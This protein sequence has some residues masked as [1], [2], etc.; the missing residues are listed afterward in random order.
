MTTVELSDELFTVTTGAI[1]TAERSAAR[2]RRW[3]L[4]A[5]SALAALLVVEIVLVLPYLGRAMTS[6]EQPDLRWVG[7]AVLT[8]L[9]SMGAFAHVQR[10][11]LSVGGA[12]V[13][14]CR[15]A[16]LTYA[17]NA[18]SVTFPGGTALSSGYVYKRLRSWGATVPA[19]GFTI[20]ASGVLSTLSFALL[21]V[22]CAVLAGNGG[23]GSLLVVAGVVVAAVAAWLVQRHHK[24]DLLVRVADR[25]LIRA[26]RVFHRAPEAGIA[27]LHRVVRDL[28]AIKPRNRDWLAGLGFAGLNWV[29]DLAC[30]IACCQAVGATGS[31][32]VLVMVAYIAGMSTSGLSLMPGGL[33]VVDAAMIFAL[34]QGGVSTV[35]ATAGVLLYRL[36]SFALVVALGWL[37]WGATWLAERRQSA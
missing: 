14:M 27:G 29:A 20:L 33:G 34:T 26:N 2:R 31:S 23:L 15:M 7:L 10:R 12:R 36:I 25:A 13:R 37:V 9:M 35:S 16:A 18:V 11:M 4:L 28:S 22:V 1:P 30:L 5:F 24:P 6:L 21:A 8:E 3:K 32:L 17:A 19:A